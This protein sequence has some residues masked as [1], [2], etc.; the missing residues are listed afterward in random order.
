MYFQKIITAP[1]INLD[2]KNKTIDVWRNMTVSELA[3]VTRIPVGK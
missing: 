3:S 1:V 2:K